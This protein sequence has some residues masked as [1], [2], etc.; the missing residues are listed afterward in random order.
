[1]LAPEFAQRY[2]SATPD[3]T[4]DLRDPNRRLYFFWDE[5]VSV[6]ELRAALE[7]GGDAH[8]RM[9]LLGK[10]L[11]EARDVDVWRFV[12]PAEVPSRCLAV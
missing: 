1:M 9:R 3:L 8:E 11:R 5:D 2:C 7:P 12:T 4:L 6:A 10:L